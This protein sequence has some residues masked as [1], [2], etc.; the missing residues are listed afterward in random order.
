MVEIKA[1]QRSREKDILE[2]ERNTAYFYAVANQRRRK[3][4]IVSLEKED[5]SEVSETKDM[6]GVAVDFYKKTVW[7]RGTIRY[8]LG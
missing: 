8:R 6:L 3:K 7:K 5:G 1:R 4:K 2:G